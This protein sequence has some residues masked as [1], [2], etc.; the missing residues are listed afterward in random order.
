MRACFPDSSVASV[1]AYLVLFSLLLWTAT[2]S[3]A[4]TRIAFTSLAGGNP[5]IY[6]ATPEGHELTRLTDHAGV[7]MQPTWSPDGTQLAFVS[8]RDG[9]SDI[10]RMRADGRQQVRLTHAVDGQTPIAFSHPA[11]SPGTRGIVCQSEPSDTNPV[12]ELWLIDP[13]GT[14]LQALSYLGSGDDDLIHP[15][16][17][18][19]GRLLAVAV[20]SPERRRDHYPDHPA[21]I[22]GYEFSDVVNY[23]LVS[24]DL[25]NIDMSPRGRMAFDVDGDIWVTEED[26]FPGV[27]ITNSPDVAETDPSWSPDGRG[28]AF[29]AAGWIVTTAAD[30]S[31]LRRIVEG[32]DPAWSPQLK[33]TVVAPSS[34]AQV[35]RAIGW[36]PH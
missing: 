28:I 24:L 18:P 27:N 9:T 6:L 4:D 36:S 1:S 14:S 35:K 26:G 23:G 5:E 3:A 20:R 21:M 15:A 32:V 34:W 8:D 11:W 13:D 31:D 2:G 17:G 22:L 25:R 7:D 30:G 12:A 29:Q 33:E 19:Y 10:W 16:W